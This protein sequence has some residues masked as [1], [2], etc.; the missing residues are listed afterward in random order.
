MTWQAEF[1]RWRIQRSTQTIGY[2]ADSRVHSYLA[3]GS[4]NKSYTYDDDGNRLTS[5]VA[6]TGTTNYSIKPGNVNVLTSRTPPGSSAVTYTT[7]ADGSVKAEGTYKLH[8]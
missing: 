2:D 5:V 1:R 4:I 8:L 3:P 6:G 7:D